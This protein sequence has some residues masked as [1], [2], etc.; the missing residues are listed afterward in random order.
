MQAQRWQTWLVQPGERHQQALTGPEASLSRVCCHVVKARTSHKQ[1]LGS[2]L[3]RNRSM[4]FF[5]CSVT[6]VHAKLLATLERLDWPVAS[7]A[8]FTFRPAN[9]TSEQQ[10]YSETHE[11]MCAGARLYQ[12]RKV[13]QSQL[14][15]PMQ[16]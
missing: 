16:K 14:Q 2:C 10:E 13:A 1:V 6:L 12:R 7:S 8:M 3:K 9:G 11:A 15:G 5:K 4:T